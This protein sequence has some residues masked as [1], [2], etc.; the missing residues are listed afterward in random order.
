MSS[1]LFNPPAPLNTIADVYSGVRAP[2]AGL[3][4]AGLRLVANPY[5]ETE[6]RSDGRRGSRDWTADGRIEYSIEASLVRGA[7]SAERG[8]FRIAAARF[9]SRV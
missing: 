2:E 9:R 5:I 7:K 3:D 4:S 6:R 1:S 8:R